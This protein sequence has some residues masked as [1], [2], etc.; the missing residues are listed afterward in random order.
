MEKIQAL[1]KNAWQEG[2]SYSAYRQLIDELREKDQTT[3][4]NHSEEFLKY[5]D[6]NITRMNKWDKHFEL[7]L[8]QKQSLPAT[9]QAQKWLVISEAW[10]GDA[11]HVVPI[12]AK[13]ADAIPE[14]EL[15]IVLRDENLELMDAFLTNG[16]RSIPKAILLD[17][18]F[19]VIETYGPRPKEAQELMLDLKS[20]GAEKSEINQKLQVWYARN[21]GQAIAEELLDSIK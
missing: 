17:A 14:V 2:M 13:L 1:L 6:L 10:C 16:G 7:A 15:R 5:T 3:G 19:E 18:N 9:L 21:K 11:A 8:E 12:I 4:D 20:E